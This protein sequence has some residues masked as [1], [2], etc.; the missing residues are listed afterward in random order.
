MTGR[1][2]RWTAV[3]AALAAW[4]HAVAGTFVETTSAHYGNFQGIDYVRHS[5]RF[6]GQTARGPYRVPFEIV[7]PASPEQGNGTVVIEPPH[8]LFGPSARDIVLGPDLLFDGRFS[9]A[10]V[11]FANQG[12]NLL[13][14]TAA[15]AV[16]AG[17]PAPVNAPPFPRDVEILRQFA[18]ALVE[19]P[20]AVAMLGRVERR[21]AYGLSQSAEALYELFYGPGAAGL[22][23]LTLLNVPLW[24]PAFARPDVL[25]A[26]PATF[27]PLADIGKV[28]FVSAEGDLLISQSLQLRNAMSHP[29]YR[30]YEVA[31]AP[32]LPQDV[33]IGEVRT[34]PLDIAPVV[35]AAFVAGDRWVTSN[36]LPPASRLLD[37]ADPN[38]IDPVYWAPTGIAR[39]ANLNAL[40]G[41]RF[42]DVESGRALHIA[43]ALDVEVL[44]GL[45]GL[46][47]LFFDLACAPA[48]GT[49]SL[50][51]R[52][53]NHGKYVGWVARQA[54]KLA[55]Q[56]FLLQEDA[57]ALI[58]A[59]AKSDVGQPGTCSAQQ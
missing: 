32:H 14:P 45:P 57:N 21:Y 6:V 46:I 28:M 54:R 22:F 44:P 25:A 29:D 38:E 13:D 37:A 12:L 3:L 20:V 27:T 40:G 8:F 48:P 19:D 50:T 59:A 41:V 16:I 47:G 23:D 11:G 17:F 24:R 51:P 42:P 2:A 4:S 58:N 49:A 10:S 34:N 31:G 43:S 33:V 56:G 15:D 35:R 36:A 5:G 9:H 53:S 26:L 18:E 55:R 7:A 30:V 39:D 1:L 52:F